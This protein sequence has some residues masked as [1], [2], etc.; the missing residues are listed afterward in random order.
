[1]ILTQPFHFES[2]SFP[3]QQYVQTAVRHVMLRQ[4]VLGIKVKIMLPFDKT[5]KSGPSDPLPD[6]VGLL[7]FHNLVW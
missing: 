5:G 4:G 6:M 2:T 3:T 1:M 7:S